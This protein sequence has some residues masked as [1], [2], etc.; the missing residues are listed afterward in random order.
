MFNVFGDS[1]PG[2]LQVAK[3]VVATVGQ[4]KEYIDE[5]QQNYELGFSPYRLH[6]NEYGIFVTPIR[7]YDGDVIVLGNVA[8]MKVGDRHLATDGIMVYFVKGD[9]SNGDIVVLQGDRGLSG[10]RDLKGD[11]GYRGPSGSRGPTEQRGVEGSGGPPG[12]IGKMGPVRARGG[13]GARGEKGDKGGTG[14]VGQ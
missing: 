1:G 9:G 14:G 3:K 2:N 13:I 12:K 6:K 8:T 7:V 4:F 10:A 11:S 5:I